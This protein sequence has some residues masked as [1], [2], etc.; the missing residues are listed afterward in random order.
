[1]NTKLLERTIH[2]LLITR[3]HIDMYES[4]PLLK[5]DFEETLFELKR[6]YGQYLNDVLFD[7][8]D[9]YCEDDPCPDIEEFIK[10][11]E[12]LVH[13]E[14]FPGQTAQLELKTSPLRFVFSDPKRKVSEVVW[15]AA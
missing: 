3:N 7:I 5:E 2:R 6:Q 15:S 12:V 10:S 14:D 13:P 4:D 1:M 8:Y 9:E 11:R